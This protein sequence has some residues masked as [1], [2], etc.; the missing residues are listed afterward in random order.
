M[1][2]QWNVEGRFLYSMKIDK[3][4]PADWYRQIAAAVESEYG[5]K[6][7]LEWKTIWKNVDNQQKAA[8]K[9]IDKSFI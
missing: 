6:L 3:W 7:R 4:L 1:G 8:I 5:F 2:V 9:E